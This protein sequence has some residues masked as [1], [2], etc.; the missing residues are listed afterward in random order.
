MYRAILCEE[1]II[2]NARFDNKWDA[3]RYCGEILVR[4]GYVYKEYVE[5]MVDREKEATVYIGN[6]VAIPHGTNGSEPYIITSGI[7]VLQVPEGVQFEDGIAYILIGIAGRDGEHIKILS[8]I[9][10][11]C[12]DIDNVQ[13]LREA[14]DKKVICSILKDME[15]I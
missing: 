5:R 7:S 8:S 9:A 1:N 15:V 4:N 6:N 3:I 10:T 2:L 12:S 11:V 14:K 13:K